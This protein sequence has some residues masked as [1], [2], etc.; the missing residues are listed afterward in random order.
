MTKSEIV[1]RLLLVE[2][3]Y[4]ENQE[5]FAQLQFEFA[6]M[7]PLQKGAVH[8]GKTLNQKYES[9]QWKMKKGTAYHE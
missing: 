9:S 5:Q 8:Q 2:Q 3:S 4:A 6:E 7:Q 1:E